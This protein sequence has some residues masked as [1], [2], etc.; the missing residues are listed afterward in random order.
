M[1]LLTYLL[2]ASL[3]LVNLIISIG[4]RPAKLH[5][6]SYAVLTTGII[7]QMIVSVQPELHK[8]GNFVGP[9]GTSASLAGN[10]L[11]IYIYIY[12]YIYVFKKYLT[13]LVNW[14]TSVVLCQSMSVCTMLIYI[15]FQPCKLNLAFIQVNKP[16][17]YVHLY[18]YIY[19]IIK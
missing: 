1:Y 18:I 17:T 7:K 12:I 10:R 2:Y 3:L 13:M 11:Y 5:N 16:F 9:E 4:I 14:P 6:C 15:I 19:N 8:S